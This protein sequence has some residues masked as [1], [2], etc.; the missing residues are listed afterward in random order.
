MAGRNKT[1][2]KQDEQGNITSEPALRRQVRGKVHRS[3]TKMMAQRMYRKSGHS[4]ACRVG[5]NRTGILARIFIRAPAALSYVYDNT[6]TPVRA[7]RRVPMI[8]PFVKFTI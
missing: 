2:E 6:M 5:K 4:H 3:Q 7:S 8:Q 1:I